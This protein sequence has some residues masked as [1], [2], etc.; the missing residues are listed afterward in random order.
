MDVTALRGEGWQLVYPNR[1]TTLH[2]TCHGTERRS[3]VD[4]WPDP[5]TV[6]GLPQT[7]QSAVPKRAG[8]LSR[9]WTPRHQSVG[10][11]VAVRATVG[12]SGIHGQ[13]VQSPK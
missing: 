9:C 13:C 6:T 4:C 5:S 8:A 12:R 7:G 10:T 2:G 11:T 1:G 3:A